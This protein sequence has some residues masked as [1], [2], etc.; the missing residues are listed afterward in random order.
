MHRL[1][2]DKIRRDPSLWERVPRTLARW[3]R[4]VDPATQPYLREWEAL[5]SQG[6]EVCLAVAT[7][8]SEHATALRQSSPFVCIL[9]H[10]ERFAF[11][12]RWRSEAS[13]AA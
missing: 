10:H 4:Q 9:T 1:V 13:H 8:R 3:R 2:A 12:K 6:M 11:L 7:E 5:A